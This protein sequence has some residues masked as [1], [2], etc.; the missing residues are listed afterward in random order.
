M[1]TVLSLEFWWNH[2]LFH[3]ELLQ[4]KSKKILEGLQ[5]IFNAEVMILDHEGSQQTIN[6]CLFSNI[7]CNLTDVVSLA[8]SSL[9]WYV[10]LWGRWSR[11]LGAGE[12][13]AV[14]GQRSDCALRSAGR[15]SQRDR[16]FATAGDGCDETRGNSPRARKGPKHRQGTPRPRHN[17]M[18]YWSCIC[19][20]Y[21]TF[22][23]VCEMV[24]NMPPILSYIFGSVAEGAGVCSP[25]TAWRAWWLGYNGKLARVV[26][27]VMRGGI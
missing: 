14:W 27:F 1:Q 11:A 19:F 22:E 21:T 5:H 6:V 20:M 10:V 13:R 3:L 2:C 23:V 8:M 4:G 17:A 15:G 16:I 18:Q 12:H 24:R 26:A 9:L 25:T 7:N